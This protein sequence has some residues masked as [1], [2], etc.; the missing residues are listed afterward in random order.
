MKHNVRITVLLLALF[1]VSQFL[2]LFLITYDVTPQ[3]VV[4]EDNV[5]RVNA[6]YSDTAMGE[7]P[8]FQRETGPL[9][10]LVIGIAIGTGILLV[11]M[12]LKSGRHLWKAWYFLAV[13]I[14]ISIA[15]GVFL[16]HTLAVII[17]VI[18]AFLKIQR[19]S[20]IIHNVT[21][22]FMYAGI[23]FLLIPLFSTMWVSLALLLLIS[24][25]DMYAVWK[26][27]HMIKLAKFTTESQL[28]AGLAIPYAVEAKQKKQEN[29][30]GENHTYK[31]FRQTSK[32]H[33]KKKTK[34]S[35]KQAILG[36]GDIVFPLLFAGT[37]LQTLIF[38]GMEKYTAL[39]YTS[40]IPL[41][42]LVALALLF[43]KGK[44]DRFYPAMP[45]LTIGCLVGYGLL[46]LLLLLV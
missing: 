32:K 28:F 35:V 24:V 18:L 6:T 39:L 40:F 1:L 41:A 4:D 2:G 17:A 29:H 19:Q 20:P 3:I 31:T 12:R 38:K 16:N 34:T 44:S 10:Y 36:G 5:T 14:A 42:A 13:V 37:V 27:K 43:F 8:E 30:T 7:R 21:E 11:L 26:S 46:H 15:L 33:A 25:Y 45:F 9:W 22:M 23:S